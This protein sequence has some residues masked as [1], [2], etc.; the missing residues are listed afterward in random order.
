MQWGPLNLGGLR[1]LLSF[2]PEGGPGEY[3][4]LGEGKDLNFVGCEERV[5]ERLNPLCE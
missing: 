3:P 5:F 4:V 1:R 2:D